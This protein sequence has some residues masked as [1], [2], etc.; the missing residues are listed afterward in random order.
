M[1]IISAVFLLLLAGTSVGKTLSLICEHD[2][3]IS[4]RTGLPDSVGTDIFPID[5]DLDREVITTPFFQDAESYVGVNRQSIIWTLELP[6]L[7][8]YWHYQ[9]NRHTGK[10]F[11]K[12]TIGADTYM[13]QG[14]CVIPSALF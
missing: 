6:N 8:H 9:L 10:L 13:A 2:G 11:L 3:G 12:R 7:G 5:F 4:I 1:R 14:R